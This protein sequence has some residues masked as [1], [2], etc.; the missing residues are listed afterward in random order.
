MEG[1]L[2]KRARRRGREGREEE[3]KKERNEH[4]T[5]VL[6]YASSHRLYNLP[7]GVSSLSTL[8]VIKK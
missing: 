5:A 1:G 7:P 2:T 6:C 4:R 8:E 3:M